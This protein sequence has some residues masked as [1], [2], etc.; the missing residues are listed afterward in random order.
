MKMLKKVLMWIGGIFLSL[1]LFVIFLGY[2]SS[3]FESEMTPFISEFVTDI[4]QEW[5]MESVS[6]RVSNDFLRQAVTPA[7]R[8]ILD[9]FRT[10]GQVQQIREIQIQN[11]RTATD[12]TTGD[13]TLRAKFE[14]ADTLI[15]ITILSTSNGP[16]VQT[17]RIDPIEVYDSAQDA[18]SEA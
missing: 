15:Q 14:T 8:Q 9:G 12:G 10:L 11:Y 13:F 1:V 6:N 18:A 7:G 17:F 16:R 4:S 3:A 2:R 5:T